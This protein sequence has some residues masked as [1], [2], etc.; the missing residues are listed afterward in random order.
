MRGYP[1]LFIRGISEKE[2]IDEQGRVSGSAFQ[3]LQT[4]REDGFSECSINWFD[5][6][7]ALNLIKGQLKTAEPKRY[8][9]HCAVVVPVSEADRIRA[10]PLYRDVFTYER[11]PL[12][13]NQYHGNLLKKDALI[14][15]QHFRTIQGLLAF[16]SKPVYREKNQ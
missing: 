15:K 13:G 11:Q 3:F 1:N 7:E 9:F 12:A 6:K 14:K 2:Y 4:E 10:N 16:V 8:Q 5:E